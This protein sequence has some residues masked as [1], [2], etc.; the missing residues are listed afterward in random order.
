V[1]DAAAGDAQI[2]T[3]TLPEGLRLRRHQGLVF[4]FNHAAETRR[5]PEGLGRDFI[6]GAEDLP[7]AGV[8]VWRE[9]ERREVQ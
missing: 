6:L 1:L 8:A 7:P 5:L 9:A 4:A 3:R 2:P